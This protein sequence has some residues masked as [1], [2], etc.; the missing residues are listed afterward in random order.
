MCE[1]STPML[2]HFTKHD[3]PI[4]L[5]VTGCHIN[6]HLALSTK[7]LTKGK[8]QKFHLYEILEIIRKATIMIQLLIFLL[9]THILYY[10]LMYG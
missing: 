5:N 6:F 4:G 9:A 7:Q 10:Y 8:P 3:N 2:I 1:T